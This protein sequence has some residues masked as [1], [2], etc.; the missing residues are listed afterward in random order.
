[1]YCENVADISNK[2]SNMPVDEIKAMRISSIDNAIKEKT[3]DIYNLERTLE[4]VEKRCKDKLEN[5]D[6]CYEIC[7]DIRLEIKKL[8][9]E[10][11]LLR[12]DKADVEKEIQDSLLW[13]KMLS[14]NGK[15]TE[16][17]RT[18]ISRLIDKIYVYEDKFRSLVN[19]SENNI[20]IPENNVSVHTRQ[21]VDVHYAPCAG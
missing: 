20:K 17:N 16:I 21:G 11:E 7:A 13:V 8:Q 6:S 4:V 3:D 1:M 19:L 5:D 12:A 18:V 15:I 14:E 9:D 10:T 2:F